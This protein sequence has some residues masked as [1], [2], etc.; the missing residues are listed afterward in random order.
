LGNITDPVRVLRAALCLLVRVRR[1]RL[2]SA[3]T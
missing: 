2:L 1:L 3:A